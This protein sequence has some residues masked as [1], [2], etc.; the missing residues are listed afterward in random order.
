MPQLDPYTDPVNEK[1]SFLDTEAI[2]FMSL[3]FTFPVIGYCIYCGVMILKV[4]VRDV[5]D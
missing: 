4:P 1:Y 5:P 3:P 2:K